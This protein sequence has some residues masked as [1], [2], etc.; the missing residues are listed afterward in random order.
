LKII[1]DLGIDDKE[2]YVHLAPPTKPDFPDSDY[3][4]EANETREEYGRRLE[5]FQKNYRSPEPR[6]VRIHN[7]KPWKRVEKTNTGIRTM[8]SIDHLFRD[9]EVTLRHQ[10]D[11]MLFLRKPEANIHIKLPTLPAGREDLRH[12]TFNVA[13]ME[14][15]GTPVPLFSAARR[16]T[17]TRYEFDLTDDKKLT[18]SGANAT[19]VQNFAN[20]LTRQF[21][22]NANH[23]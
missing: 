12:A 10:D 14:I 20:E 17:D 5:Q 7:P 3:S 23:H 8:Y 4:A 16:I 19:S 1:D 22:L 2:P 18:I 15:E 9:L 11:T 21:A 6:R 13:H